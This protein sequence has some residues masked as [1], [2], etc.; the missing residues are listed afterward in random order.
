MLIVQGKHQHL[1]RE[2]LMT[3]FIMCVKP[4]WALN[5]SIITGIFKCQ[6]I[7]YC[8]QITIF[9][10]IKYGVFF[11][12]YFYRNVY[13][14]IKCTSVMC[15]LLCTLDWFKC[16]ST[17]STKRQAAHKTSQGIWILSILRWKLNHLLERISCYFKMKPQLQ[18]ATVTGPSNLIVLWPFPQK[19]LVI[20]LLWHDEWN[21]Y[22]S[23][24]LLVV[25]PPHSLKSTIH[26]AETIW[27]ALVTCSWHVSDHT[28]KS[29]DPFT[30]L[31]KVAGWETY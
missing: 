25:P 13:N 8:N 7:M 11:S 20:R 16:R 23:I 22:N 21:M 17:R 10:N 26:H 4:V 14:P 12:W 2:W 27:H 28:W 5:T 9:I 29:R 15:T 30:A 19:W 6:H 24:I 18:G 1:R 3:S 31:E